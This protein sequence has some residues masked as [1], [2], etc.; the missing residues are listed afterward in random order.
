M[1]D[2]RWVKIC[3]NEK[4]RKG[5]NDQYGKERESYY[6]SNGWSSRALEMLGSDEDKRILNELEH[7]DRDV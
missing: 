4:A 3:W 2:K 5:W 6:N 1:T 7:R